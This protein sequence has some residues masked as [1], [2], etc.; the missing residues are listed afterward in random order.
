MFD[1]SVLDETGEKIDTQVQLNQP[2]ELR[3]SLVAQ[4]VALA[5]GDASLIIVQHYHPEEGWE[6]LPTE[7][8][9][10][11][12]TATALTERLSIFALTVIRPE[13]ETLVTPQLVPEPTAA[14]APTQLS[15]ATPTPLPTPTP[16]PT[17]VPA[18]TAV[19]APTPIPTATPTPEPTVAPAPTAIPTPARPRVDGF[20]LR[21][22]GVTVPARTACMRTSG[23]EVCVFPMTDSDGSYAR[24]MEVTI[25]AFPDRANYQVTWGGTDSFDGTIATLILT[26]DRDVTLVM[27]LRAAVPTPTGAPS[28]I[29]ATRTPGIS[30]SFGQRAP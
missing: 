5:G 9:F 13:E 2:V 30:R 8:D 29:V 19:P 12:A 6:P 26:R 23:G 22:N 4:D 20:L 17:P 1:L 24:G 14:P 16:V 11:T 28:S 25:G 27:A 15:T 7:V 21:I 10:V 18:A 3:V